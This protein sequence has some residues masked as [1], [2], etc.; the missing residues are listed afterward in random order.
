MLPHGEGLS[1]P[2]GPSHVLFEDS[3]PK[4]C[5]C[6]L[7]DWMLA[8]DEDEKDFVEQLFAVQAHDYLMFFTNIGRVYW[9]KALEIPDVGVAGRGKAI[10]NSATKPAVAANSA[11][12]LL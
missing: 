5:N 10:A 8:K 6:G 11:R 7:S 2:Y 4:E 1:L 3:D 9:L 12:R